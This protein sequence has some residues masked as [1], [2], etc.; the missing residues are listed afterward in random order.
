MSDTQ[1]SNLF[2]EIENLAGTI[3]RLEG[4]QKDWRAAG[5]RPMP[6]PPILRQ[7]KELRVGS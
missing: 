3:Y 1:S 5:F 4:F 7:V 6:Q 2:L